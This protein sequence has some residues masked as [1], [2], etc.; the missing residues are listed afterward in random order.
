MYIT[1]LC[2]TK[3]KKSAES[4]QKKFHCGAAAVAAGC[5]HRP[6]CPDTWLSN[7]FK[8]PLIN[9]FNLYFKPGRKKLKTKERKRQSAV[10]LC[11]KIVKL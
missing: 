4:E 10:L 8:C 6:C 3:A 5:A 9:Q 1:C 2:K 7:K 11:P